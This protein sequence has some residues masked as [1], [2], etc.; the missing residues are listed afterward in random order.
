MSYKNIQKYTVAQHNTSKTKQLVMLYEGLLK[1]IMNTKLSIE[2]KDFTG[3]YNNLERATTII[4]G[5]QA[6]L[7]FTNGGDIAKI[8]YD[9]YQS[10]YLR[11]MSVNINNDVQI[12]IDIIDELSMMK[13]AW[14]EVDQIASSNS[15][16]IMSNPNEIPKSGMEVSA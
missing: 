4:L 11:L 1:L 3:R 14:S 12:C 8:L 7:D 6:S 9:L 16:P 2:Q 15:M 13:E 5:L 10:L